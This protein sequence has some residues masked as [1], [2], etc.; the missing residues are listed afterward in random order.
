MLTNCKSPVNKLSNAITDNV[1]SFDKFNWLHARC[2]A[3]L[4]VQ[5]ARE[6][7]QTQ[8]ARLNGKAI[9][10]EMTSLFIFT[11]PEHDDIF[12]KTEG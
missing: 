4:R 5:K 12:S 11:K 2:F 3:Q 9:D 10:I 1:S 6:D 8:T 7:S